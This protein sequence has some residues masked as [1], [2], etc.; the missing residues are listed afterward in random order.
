MRL[1]LYDPL[2]KGRKPLPEGTVREYSGMKFKKMGGKWIY[3]AEGEQPVAEEAPVVEKEP[4][5]EK[6][7]KLTWDVTK[8]PTQAYFEQEVRE[9]ADK[10]FEN[11]LGVDITKTMMELGVGFNPSMVAEG[12]LYY[13]N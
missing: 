11:G 1:V 3:H 8:A 13:L 2:E 9:R 6:N 12:T 7:D 5:A 10:Y 4:I